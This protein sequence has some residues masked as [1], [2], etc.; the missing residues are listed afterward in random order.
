MEAQSQ[1]V[2]EM[3]VQML[4]RYQQMHHDLSA[5]R[6]MPP[7]QL[8]CLISCYN[9]DVKCY[10]GAAVQHTTARL[11]ALGGFDCLFGAFSDHPGG[12]S[13]SIGSQLAPCIDTT[14][15]PPSSDLRRLGSG[16]A[17]RHAHAI[18]SLLS[19]EESS[20]LC[21]VIAGIGYRAVVPEISQNLSQTLTR[22][23]KLCLLHDSG[24]ANWLWQRLLQCE[25]AVIPADMQDRESRWVP[26]GISPCIKFNQYEE[27]QV[28]GPHADAV[29]ESLTADERTFMTVLVYL[30]EGFDG[31]HTNFLR[32][33]SGPVVMS[34][35][36]VCG[37]GLVFQHDMLHE[38]TMPIGSPRKMIMQ[39]DMLF[40]RA[41]SF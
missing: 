14:A 6:Q 23:H 17:P 11:H 16:G 39:A 22:T 7:P 18:A 13:S 10:S 4:Q 28:F 5:D 25:P 33:R 26:V 27:G 31:G 40:K 24:L 30:N 34:V 1:Q 3:E 2:D 29:F 41:R 8:D 32:S 35:A 9:R 37:N 20:E 19:S 36:P 21:R 38:A 15:K 12:A